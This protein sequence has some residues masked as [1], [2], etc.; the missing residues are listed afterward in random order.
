MIP[1][2]EI[3]NYAQAFRRKKVSALDRNEIAG[4]SKL[5]LGKR[6]NS[7]KISSKFIIINFLSSWISRIHKI[8]CTNSAIT[9]ATTPICS[10]NTPH[11]WIPKKLSPKTSGFYKKKISSKLA[12]DKCKRRTVSWFQRWNTW[13]RNSKG[14]KRE[15]I[16]KN[17]F[18]SN[19]ST[20]APQKIVTSTTDQKLHSKTI[21]RESTE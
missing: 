17:D 12:S 7:Q 8:C 14:T 19:P 9:L 11:C 2:T 1:V 6:I 20:N 4:R 18:L 5:S 21:W 3:I 15:G 10:H 13:K 16:Q